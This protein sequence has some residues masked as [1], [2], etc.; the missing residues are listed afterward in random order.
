M[1]CFFVGGLVVKRRY[2]KMYGAPLLAWVSCWRCVVADIRYKRL[3]RVLQAALLAAKPSYLQFKGPFR[4]RKLLVI[5]WSRRN[6]T[7]CWL[8]TLVTALNSD[9]RR[10]FC[11]RIGVRRRRVGSYWQSCFVP[12][13]WAI[14]ETMRRACYSS[15][16]CFA[17]MVIF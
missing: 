17:E 10:T 7:L 1:S 5:Y 8:R 16:Y 9:T 4:L 13:F 12:T 14:H 6:E 2:A 3:K 11:H 15:I